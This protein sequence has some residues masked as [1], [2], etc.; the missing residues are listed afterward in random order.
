VYSED[1]LNSVRASEEEMK[2]ITVA[3]GALKPKQVASVSPESLGEW[4]SEDLRYARPYRSNEAVGVVYGSGSS[5][6]HHGGGS[7]YVG[8]YYRANGTYV[9]SYTRSSGSHR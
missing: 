1:T 8:G 5:G 6:R 9:H 4:S 7:V 2:A 3:R